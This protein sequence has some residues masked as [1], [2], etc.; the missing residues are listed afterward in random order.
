MAPAHGSVY[1]GGAEEYAATY[2]FGE[3]GWFQFGQLGVELAAAE[4]GI[5]RDAWTHNSAAA[6]ASV[7]GGVDLPLGLPRLPGGTLVLVA[8]LRPSAGAAAL[9]HL[10]LDIDWVGQPASV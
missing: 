4:L 7:P 1:D 3:L 5:P 8:F 9:R 10:V 6:F 2:R